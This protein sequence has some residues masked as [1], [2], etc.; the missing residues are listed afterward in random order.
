MKLLG[1]LPDPCS[2]TTI[3]II[4][5]SKEVKCAEST[6]WF[7]LRD[8]RRL[9]GYES[10]SDLIEEYKASLRG[11][12]RLMNLKMRPSK[13]LSSIEKELLLK[14]E[15]LLG[16]KRDTEIVKTEEKAEKEAILN[17]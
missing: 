12:Y 7:A 16:L 4:K 15:R 13:P 11:L 9:K 8:L 5:I 17:S 14:I 3:Q 10:S 1:L 2:P 6:A